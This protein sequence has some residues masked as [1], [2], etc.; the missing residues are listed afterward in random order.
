MGKPNLRYLLVIFLMFLVSLHKF[1]NRDVG[2]GKLSLPR[3]SVGSW[4]RSFN[5][6]IACKVNMSFIQ[7]GALHREVKNSKQL[8]LCVFYAK[9]KKSTQM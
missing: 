4:L 6:T 9:F 1:S 7:H 3:Q 2:G 5:K 8:N